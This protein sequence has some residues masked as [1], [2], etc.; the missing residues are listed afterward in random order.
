ML[1]SQEIGTLI[2]ALGTS[3]G[4]D[5]FN[6][7]KLRYHK[8]II[9]T[10]ADVDGAH[11][12]T[13]LLTFFFRQMP[14]LIERGHIYI[15]QPPLYKVSR[16]KSIQYLKNEGALEEYLIT[17]GLEEAT[18]TLGSGE[19]RAGQDMREVIQD[20]LRLRSL[21]EGLHSR[22]SRSIIEQA[23]IAGALNPELTDNHERAQQTADE[24]ARR[25][26]MIAEETERGWSGHVTDE[27]GLRFE[28]MVR[29]VKEV[30]AVDVAL[31]GSA[32]ARHIDQMTPRLQEIYR[33]A[34]P[35]A[36]GRPA[37]NVRPPRPPGI[38]LRNRPQGPLHAALQGPRRDECRAAL[39]NDARSERPL[40]AAGQGERCDR[41]RW[42]LLT[43]D[44]RRSRTAPRVHPG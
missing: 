30:A 11:I 23:A 5:E 24:V 14:D 27:G 6:A 42:S 36:Q 38:D 33:T 41:C 43:P 32:D 2:T 9:M 34:R 29:G 31:I 28:R 18:L 8:I 4:K 13:L 12:R 19:V 1:G 40:A 7:D 44:G 35:H 37:G 15:A 26:D 25:L 22:Y 39:G 3:I 17:M 16:G 21:V 10:D 20:A